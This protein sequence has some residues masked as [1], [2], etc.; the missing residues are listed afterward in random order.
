MGQVIP[1]LNLMKARLAQMPEIEW[2][3]FSDCSVRRKKNLDSVIH[4]PE[5][6]GQRDFMT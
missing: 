6:Y 4:D 2:I 3:P 5:Q 1:F